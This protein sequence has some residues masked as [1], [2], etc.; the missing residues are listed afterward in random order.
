M[1]KNQARYAFC[2][3]MLVLIAY[4]YA[5][6]KYAGR[7]KQPIPLSQQDKRT[8][9]YASRAISMYLKMCYLKDPGSLEEIKCSTLTPLPGNNIAVQ[10]T[11]RAK[12]SFNN[13]VIADVLCIFDQDMNLIN[14]DGQELSK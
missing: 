13:T 7:E 8:Q 2:V 1:K 5:I 3:F 12:N 10:Y 9:K 4:T 11:Y 14:I 6:I